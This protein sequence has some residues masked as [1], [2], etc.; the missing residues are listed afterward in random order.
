MQLNNKKIFALSLSIIYF[1][2]FFASDI[3]DRMLHKITQDHLR[4][5]SFN[6][7]NRWQD[8]S[9]DNS[10][11]DLN[12]RWWTPK[13][14]K[15]LINYAVIGSA[16]FVV[17][18]SIFSLINPFATKD[19]TKK[20]IDKH[21]KEITTEIAKL[22]ATINDRFRTT[23]GIFDILQEKSKTLFENIVIK[24]ANQKETSIIINKH[25]KIFDQ[26]KQNT[27]KQITLVD[28]FAQSTSQ[29]LE[30]INKHNQSIDKHQELINNLINNIDEKTKQINDMSNSLSQEN[31]ECD[32]ELFELEKIV[33][34]HETSLKKLS[35]T[36]FQSVPNN[37]TNSSGSG[38][39]VLEK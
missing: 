7:N 12:S 20:I 26:H 27:D 35:N 22:Q 34:L 32:K 24:L 29:H 36:I 17:G 10:F 2:R 14:T 16:I 9:R 6:F 33:D 25:E 39:T 5:N 28:T 18:T 31:H 13:D 19:S 37:S 21:D 38:T 8:H 11:F 3:S 1:C 15:K 30:L 4:N 23:N